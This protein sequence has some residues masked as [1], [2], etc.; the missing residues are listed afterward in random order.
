MSTTV[1]ATAPSTRNAALTAARI[2]A[3][4]VGGLQLA[5][6][7]YFM[8]IEPDEEAVW[9]GPWID[10]PIVAVL[11]TGVALKLTTA[12]APA[13]GTA[14]RI[15]IGFLAVGIGVAVT[16]LK[17]PLYGEPEGATFLVLDALLGWLLWRARRPEPTGY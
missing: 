14:L 10:Y 6:F 16:L 1:S 9:L 2:V 7:S 12:V 11:L 3:A 15:R 8:L 5:G 4:V 13:L 17:V